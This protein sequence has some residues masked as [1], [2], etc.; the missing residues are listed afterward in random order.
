MTAQLGVALPAT[1]PL[2]LAAAPIEVV[3]WRIVPIA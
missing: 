2:A 1:P 3:A